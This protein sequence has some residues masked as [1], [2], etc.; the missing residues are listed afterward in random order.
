LKDDED[1]LQPNA[2]WLRPAVKDAGKTEAMAGANKRN[3]AG[4][5]GKQPPP[6]VA[7]L[8]R[9]RPKSEV[10][11]PRTRRRSLGW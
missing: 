9:E 5:K 2:V 10:D 1:D 4:R 3:A 6:S 8:R 11:P 7:P